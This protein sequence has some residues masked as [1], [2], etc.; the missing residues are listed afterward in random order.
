MVTA[1]TASK[2]GE[3]DR[4]KQNKKRR[5]PNYNERIATLGVIMPTEKPRV[6]VTVDIETYMWLEAVARLKKQSLSECMK[7]FSRAMLEHNYRYLKPS[8][9][10]VEDRNQ[11]AM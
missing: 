7:Q 6:N 10:Q 5:Q 2:G 4:T 11:W 1:T 3:E 9:Q 8:V